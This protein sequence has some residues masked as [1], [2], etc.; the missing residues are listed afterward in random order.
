M[1][2]RLT[3]KLGLI[4]LVTGLAL[5]PSSLLG[6]AG[7]S[8]TVE[9]FAFDPGASTIVIPAASHTTDFYIVVHTGDASSFGAVLGFTA[10]LASGS[11]TGQE[12]QID[13]PL[14]DGEYLWPMLH[15]DGNGNGVYDDP[16]TDPPIADS[17]SGNASFGGILVFRMLVAATAATQDDTP[18][19]QPA[20]TG[21]AG[22][23]QGESP[24][25]LWLLLVP[26]TIGLAGAR[27]RTRR[28]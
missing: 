28:A 2:S 7:T 5:L 4:G 3:W 18:S 12:I 6:Q 22:I 17:S 19:P 24:I 25:A 26:L 10:L 14:V 9:D 13:R 27:W 8:L 16:A 23:V 20:D 21:S 11:V 1:R 15:T